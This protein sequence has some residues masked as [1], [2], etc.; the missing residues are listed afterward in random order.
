[1]HSNFVPRRPATTHRAVLPLPLQARSRATRDRIL[2]ALARLLRTRT[3]DQISVAELTAAARCSM[4]SFYA[5]FPTKAALLN[6][7]YDRFFDVS[8]ERS[9]A[10]LAQAAA[11][12]PPLEHRARHLVQFM[13][14]SY[15]EYRGLLRSLILHSRTHPDSDFSDRTR[16]HKSAVAD[17]ILTLLVDDPQ[18]RADPR[19]AASVRFGLWLVV[20]AIEQIVLFDDPV[21]GRAPMAEAQL[22]EE[23][24][25]VLR[26][27][28]ETASA[29]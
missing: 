26:R 24:T 18:Q 29:P 21:M 3:F 14:G 11:G 1:V 5:R 28:V 13:L 22:V 20:Q 9:G 23:L 6:A 19:A 10:A 15:R 17:A 8:A 16:A 25:S 7:F 12:R 4:S 2:A 27:A